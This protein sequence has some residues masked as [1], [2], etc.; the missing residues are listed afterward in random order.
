MINFK[1]V[2]KNYY[3]QSLGELC[4]IQNDKIDTL[5]STFTRNARAAEDRLRRHLQAQ[6]V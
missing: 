2:L 5:I 1:A 6:G 4:D 3:K